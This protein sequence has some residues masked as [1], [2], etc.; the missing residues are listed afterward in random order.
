MPFAAGYQNL[1]I[2][3]IIERE[4]IRVHF[5][6]IYSVREKKVI[7]FEG[8]SRGIHPATE[9]I[10]PPT[11]LIKQAKEQNLTL[12]LDRVFRK[13][14]L[15]NFKPVHDQHPDTILFLNLQVSILDKGVAGSG[16]L[17]QQ[18]EDIGLKPE[19]VVIEILESKVDL[20]KHLQEF[21]LRHRSYG[22]SIALDDVGSGHSNLNRISLLQPDIIKIDRSLVTKLQKDY[23]RQEVFKSLVQLSQ[24]IGAVILAEGVEDEAETLTSLSLGAELLQG[25]YFSEPKELKGNFRKIMGEKLEPIARKF[26]GHMVELM[27]IRKL[28]HERFGLM[29]ENLLED[30]SSS[31]ERELEN[32]AL[33]AIRDHS[34]ARA[35]Y[36][37][38]EK[39]KQLTPMA[40][41]EPQTRRGIFRVPEVGTDHSLRDYFYGLAQGGFDH[42][43]FTSEPYISPATGFCVTISSFFKD[44]KGRKLILCV[45]VLP[46]YLKNMDRILS[47]FEGHAEDENL[48]PTT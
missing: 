31:G 41:K 26:Q 15:E 36:V 40:L 43:T 42:K 3:D 21:V 35:V 14:I 20:L 7:G 46:T 25:F 1:D 28:Q 4:L 18:V 38:D 8:L 44:R 16:H 39:G 32:R 29:L 5:Q 19:N 11:V 22:F 34:I 27:N 12:E 2:R 48:D 17:R 13:K 24:K 9:Q 47:L 10:I 45:D 23:Y 33:Q 6:P 37:L 30:F